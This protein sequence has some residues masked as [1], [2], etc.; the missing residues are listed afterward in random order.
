MA[1]V[2]IP[3]SW[4]ATPLSRQPTTA[5]NSPVVTQAGGTTG[6]SVNTTSITKYGYG[7]PLIEVQTGCTADPAALAGFLTTYLGTPLPRQPVIRLNLMARSDAERQIILGIGFGQWVQI[8]SAPSYWAPGTAN[9]TIIG[10]HHV[11]GVETR[12]VEWS[13]SALMGSA[14][15]APGPWFKLDTSSFD[16]TDVVPF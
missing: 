12:I 5:V 10:I 8:T 1:A 7:A 3:Y 13:T 11:M 9:F 15:T 16:G 2:Q 14:P 6:Y 4:I